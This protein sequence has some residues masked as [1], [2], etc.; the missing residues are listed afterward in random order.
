MNEEE[1]ESL[2]GMLTDIIPQEKFSVQLEAMD[3][4]ANPFIITQ[5]EFMRRMKEMQQSGG[6]MFGMGAMPDMYNL[7]VN[8]NHEL[9]GELLTIKTQKKKERLVNQALDLARLSQNLLK[10]KDLSQFIKR[11]FKMIK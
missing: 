2:K 7:V 6:G 5:P 3:S 11:S 8:T 9:I 10:G 1:N 4:K